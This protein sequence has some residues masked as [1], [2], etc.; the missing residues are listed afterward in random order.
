MAIINII[1]FPALDGGRILFLFIEKIKG[2]PIN[3]KIE[4][5][6]IEEIK[7]DKDNKKF[8]I[9]VN[10]PRSDL[11]PHQSN[12]SAEV[13]KYYRRSNSRIREMEQGEIEDLFFKRK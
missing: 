5:C 11:A 13:K 6:E 7:S 9:I 2:S 1:P 12:K 10:V 4:G 8:V 3:R